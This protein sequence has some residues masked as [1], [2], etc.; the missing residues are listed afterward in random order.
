VFGMAAGARTVTMMDVVASPSD[1]NTSTR[2]D[3]SPM[4]SPRGMADVITNPVAAQ[5]GV[6]QLT[7]GRVQPVDMEIQTAHRPAPDLHAG[8]VAIVDQR[9]GVQLL[10]RGGTAIDFDSRDRRTAHGPDSSEQ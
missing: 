2:T 8:E 3:A 1:Q 4:S 5:I 10:G 6:E 7:G 9:P